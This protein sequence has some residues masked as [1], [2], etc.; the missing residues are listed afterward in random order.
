MKKTGPMDI[1]S[2]KLIAFLEETGRKNKSGLWTRISLELSKPT[3]SRC[4]MN[5]ARLNRITK[6]GE[7]VAFAGKLLGVGALDHELTIAAFKASA[8]IK[9]KIGASKL[10]TLR[11]LAE[12]NPTGSGIRIVK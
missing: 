10:M 6:A 1:Q 9:G 5:L 12:K 3:R 7:T 4:E 2:R 8:S 11:E